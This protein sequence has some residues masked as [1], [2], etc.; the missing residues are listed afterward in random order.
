[1][2]IVAVYIKEHKF[3]FNN[4][5]Q[6]LNFGGKYFYIF[7]FITDNEITIYKKTKNTSKNPVMLI[8]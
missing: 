3:L 7:K 1:M 2:R 5:S 4:E 6:V 8:K